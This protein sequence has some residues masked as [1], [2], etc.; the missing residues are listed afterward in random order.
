M[1]KT[2][3]KFSYQD[4]VLVL[5]ITAK[6][7]SSKQEIIREP[8]YELPQPPTFIPPTNNIYDAIV[9]T[10]QVV[11]I[12]DAGEAYV[13]VFD[14]TLSETQLQ[15][16]QTNSKSIFSTVLKIS[17]TFYNPK[18]AIWEPIIEGC[19]FSLDV[20]LNPHGDP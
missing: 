11:V 3:C 17:S 9:S 4:L 5:S 19:M 8:I 16:Q 7:K 6:L 10:L 15:F 12:N 14:L 18:I 2:I 1:D 20:S 13:P